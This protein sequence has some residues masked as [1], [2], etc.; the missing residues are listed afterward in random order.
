MIYIESHRTQRKRMR[1][2]MM[3]QK[4][5]PLTQTHPVKMTKMRMRR[6]MM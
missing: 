2:K 5:L 4:R 1:M 3:S 6:T